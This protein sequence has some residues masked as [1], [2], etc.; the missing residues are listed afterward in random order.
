MSERTAADSPSGLTCLASQAAYLL[1]RLLVPSFPVPVIWGVI[2]WNLALNGSRLPLVTWALLSLHV[3]CFVSCQLQPLQAV[4][5]GPE[6][7]WPLCPTTHRP[8]PPRS[9]YV[10]R[11]GGVVI[12][13]DHWCFWLETP[14]GLHNRKGFVLY[15]LYSCLLCV[16]GAHVA[17][18]AAVADTEAMLPPAMASALQWLLTTFPVIQLFLWWLGV[19]SGSF[20]GAQLFCAILD[21][22]LGAGLFGFGTYQLHLVLR[23]QTT[24]CRQNSSG[25]SSGNAFDVGW[26]ANWRQVMGERPL[27][28]L[29]P[30]G[31][32]GCDGIHWPTR[33]AFMAAKQV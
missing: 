4:T 6:T 26:R 12:G 7:D 29:L 19:E 27:L 25:H 28:W 17:L 9:R 24:V 13:F 32:P 8:I 33:P 22:L 30:L 18:T 11:A 31:S 1:R 14:I 16:S 2:G 21:L 20:Q 15:L 10:R 3:V 23:N 5:S